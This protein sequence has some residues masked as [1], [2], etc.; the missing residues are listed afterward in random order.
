MSAPGTQ[1]SGEV[2][3]DRVAGVRFGYGNADELG[4]ASI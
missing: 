1:T 2:V 3:K 4:R